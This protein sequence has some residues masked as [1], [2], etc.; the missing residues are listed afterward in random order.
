[1]CINNNIKLVIFAFCVFILILVN[2]ERTNMLVSDLCVINERERKSSFV[3]PFW[4]KPKKTGVLCCQFY[5]LAW[6]NG[7]PYA[8]DYCYLKG[9]FRMQGWKGREQTIFT[10]TKEM[11]K[12]TRKFLSKEQPSILH[13]GEL[14]DSL[15]APGSDQIMSKLV[16]LFGVQ[17]KHTLLL[18]T[19][20]DNVD[21]LLNLRHNYRTVVGFS[22]NSKRVAKRFE[23]GAPSTQRRLKA[24]RKC[25]EAGYPVMVRVDPMIPIE[26]WE[27]DYGDLFEQ[28]N[29]MALRGVV[30]GTLRAYQSLIPKIGGEL[31]T[32]L[33]DRERDRRYHIDKDL[34]NRMYNFAFSMLNHK[35]MGICKEMG[36]LWGVLA[37]KY[38]KR[39]ICN[40]KCD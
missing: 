35:R 38:H 28:L 39:F 14:S 36:D 23:I 27:K 2:V 3:K 19:K 20:S 32:M 7:C 33:V 18:L 1:M 21:F 34:R 5:E 25:I 26:D 16:T 30:V 24:A 11:I 29:H 22:I 9:T 17:N 40:C 4:S 15:A 12:E 37:T 6:S 8:C 13:T 10:N 31:R